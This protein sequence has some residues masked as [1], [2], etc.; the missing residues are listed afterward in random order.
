MYPM[1]L[2]LSG[3]PEA[4]AGKMHEKWAAMTDGQRLAIQVVS[5]G[6]KA[7]FIH[8]KN[9]LISEAMKYRVDGGRLDSN[10]TM[11]FHRFLER[12][13][14]IIREQ[15]FANL[16]AKDVIPQ[17]PDGIALGQKYLTKLGFFE[18]GEAGLI[19]T[20]L[21]EVPYVEI[22]GKEQSVRV[23]VVTSAFFISTLQQAAEAVASGNFGINVN[24]QERKLRA[25]NRV[26]NTREDVLLSYGD[27]TLGIFGALTLDASPNNVETMTV[28]NGS[29][30]DSG[31]TADD[32]VSD[33]EEIRVKIE[34][35]SNNTLMMTDLW[36]PTKAW[37]GLH[38]RLGDTDKS[39]LSY[40]QNTYPEIR[41]GKWWRCDAVPG[42]ANRSIAFV[43][44]PDVL[45]YHS[46]PGIE[47]APMHHTKPTSWTQQMMK[48]VGGVS[49]SAPNGIVYPTNLVA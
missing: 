43:R 11:F 6:R 7:W 23:T 15:K 34:T 17:S 22:M 28:T 33:V 5:E 40:L 47:M 13:S 46:G 4:V 25:A 48:P 45:E 12:I 1:N 27:A 3:I 14:T 9:S 29:W 16:M 8:A 41:F 36:L 37:G 26:I 18:V 32:I 44:D 42:A 24:I 38:R 35:D 31:T 19:E 39:I 20:G 30:D 2:D 21:E 49:T 10:E